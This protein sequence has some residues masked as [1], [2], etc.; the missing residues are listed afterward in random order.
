M[1]LQDFNRSPF[2]SKR[3]STPYASN[4]GE[5]FDFPAGVVFINNSCSDIKAVN[6]EPTLWHHNNVERIIEFTDGAITVCVSCWYR[7]I[8][9]KPPYVDY[10]DYPSADLFNIYDFDA[11]LGYKQKSQRKLW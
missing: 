10:A 8:F 6:L 11:E 1:T 2:K 5:L 9:K 4:K 3:D 7:D